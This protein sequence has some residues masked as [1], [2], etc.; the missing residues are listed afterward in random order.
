VT[1]DRGRA[2]D[3]VH[4]VFLK[5][6]EDGSLPRVVDAKAYL[7]ASVRN[8]VLNDAKV[9]QRN[10]ALDPDLAWFAP[11]DR[12]FAGEAKLRR[13][14]SGLPDDQ[15]EVTI[16]HV[17]GELTFSQIAEV[18][19]IQILRHRDIVMPLPSCA[20]RCA[21]R[22]TPVPSLDDEQFERY[23]KQFRPLDPEPLPAKARTQVTPRPSIFVWAGAFASVIFA[24]ALAVHFRAKPTYLPHGANRATVVEKAA[25]WEP[26]T[27]RHANALLAESPSV[28]AALDGVAFHSQSAQLPK[29]ERSALDVLSKEKT[30][31]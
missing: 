31:L 2:Q 11:P 17:W 1:G 30:K 16:L 28:K 10:V 21:Q 22:R 26:L 5:L 20:K 18:L 29:G 7:F 15:R 8:T 24:V 13:A 14:L 19:A 27:V 12:D 6:I 4:Q 23:L 25:T 9:R 3:A